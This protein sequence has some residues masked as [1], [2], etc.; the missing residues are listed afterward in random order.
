MTDFYACSDRHRIWTKP[1]IELRPGMSMSKQGSLVL[2]PQASLENFNLDSPTRSPTG[3][4]GSDNPRS[5]RLGRAGTQEESA[6][7]NRL[8][9]T[10]YGLPKIEEDAVE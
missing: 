5:G 7:M 1:S 9:D 6:M 8:A 3:K 4:S 10:E 2:K